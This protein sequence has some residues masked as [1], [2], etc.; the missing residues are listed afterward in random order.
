M[1]KKRLVANAYTTNAALRTLVGDPLAVRPAASFIPAQYLEAKLPC[2]RLECP[3]HLTLL[4]FSSMYLVIMAENNKKGEK[5]KA[6]KMGMRKLR[7]EILCRDKGR[8]GMNRERITH[9]CTLHRAN[10]VCTCNKPLLLHRPSP[11]PMS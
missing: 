4:L 2:V 9:E 1:Q 7:F 10:C 3:V 8:R 5:H 11:A 6:F